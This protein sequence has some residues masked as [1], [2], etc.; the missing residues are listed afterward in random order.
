MPPPTKKNSV[1]VTCPRCGYTQPEQRQAYSTICKNCHQHFRIEEA[2]KPAVKPAKILVEQRRVRC[3]QCGTELEA[4]K[5]AASTM[6][7]RCSSY[8]DLSDYR[9]TSTVSKNFRTHGWLVVEEKGYLLNTD[10]LAAEAVIKG[11]VI[12]KVTAHGSL[13]LHSTASIKGSF[14]AGRLVIPAGQHF[15]WPEA[16]RIGG[17]EIG[18]ELVANVE[19]SGTVVLKTTA[20]MFGDLTAANLVVEEGAVFVGR[21]R[22]GKLEGNPKS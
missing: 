16:L 19:A 13:E 10:S 2:L 5:A 7:K 6:C 9:I 21:A 1:P 4:P 20:R 18:G 12:G 14:S 17:A 11:R 22:V 8:V 15:R 3:F